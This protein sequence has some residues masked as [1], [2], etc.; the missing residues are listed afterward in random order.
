MR[1]LH[2]MIRVNDLDESIRFYCDVLGMQL[3]RRK[4]YPS[5]RFTLAFVGY[6]GG[7]PPPQV[8]EPARAAALRALEL[9]ES[10]AA[11]HEALGCVLWFYD[12]DFPAAERELLRAL[13]LNPGDAH[14]VAGAHHGAFHDSI[15]LQFAGDLD[16]RLVAAFVAHR[17][18][19]G[20]HPQC[21]DLG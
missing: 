15:H 7:A 3:L 1:M 5:G 6:W 20:D 13:E 11:A 4:D 18:S 2:T 14:A 12:W 10:L 16:E 17:G 21:R 9:D 19:A 8:Y